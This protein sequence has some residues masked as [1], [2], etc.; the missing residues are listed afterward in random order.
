MKQEGRDQCERLFV[1]F[2]ELPCCENVKKQNPVM[3]M[4]VFPPPLHE[5]ISADSF[6][7]YTGAILYVIVVAGKRDLN[8]FFNPSTE[9][10]REQPNSVSIRSHTH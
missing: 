6:S 4:P 2:G 9:W 1:P 3:W 7:D 5:D 8:K 10:L